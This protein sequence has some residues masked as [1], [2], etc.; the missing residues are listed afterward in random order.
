MPELACRYTDDDVMVFEKYFEIQ[1]NS[2]QLILIPQD[3]CDC[4]A[5]S[6]IAV[7]KQDR[8]NIRGRC[9]CLRSRRLCFT[10]NTRTRPET[11]VLAQC[12]LGFHLIS[13]SAFESIYLNTM[14][15]YAMPCHA[16]P[17]ISQILLFHFHRPRK[18]M[19]ASKTDFAN[20]E[21]RYPE[22]VFR[23]SSALLCSISS[24]CP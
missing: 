10:S 19:P 15:C 18:Q 1:F 9:Q 5:H 21:E 3:A 11:D 22:A 14:H 6:Y 24:P 4:N 12:K 20:L 2:S 7:L 16:H 8:Y 13:F 17:G 23:L